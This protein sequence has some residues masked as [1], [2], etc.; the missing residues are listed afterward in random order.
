MKLLITG[1]LGHIGSRLIREVPRHFPLSELVMIDNLSTQRYTSLFN[2]PCDAIYRF[3]EDDV[4]EADL[5]SL[6]AGVD[7]VIHLAAI[8]DAAGSFQIR[9]KIELVNYNTTKKVADS[10]VS[11]GIPMIHLSSTSVYGTQKIT[12]DEDCSEE[13]LRP[14]SPYAETKLREERLLQEMAASKGL[15][16]VTCRF[17]TIVGISP[18]M[19]F[20]TAAN[21][22]CWQ[23]VLGHPL[24]VWRTALHQKRPYLAIN[25][26]MDALFFL[27]DK[28]CF[29]GRVYNV[30]TE[31]LTVNDVIS[32]IR[33]HVGE[34]M[35]DYVD[36]EIMNQLSY[37]VSSRR[38][39]D[40][41]FA[42]TGSIEKN[43]I[44][45][46]GILQGAG[47]YHD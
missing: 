23:A 2:L 18:G 27:L 24:T 6:M 36:A 14:Q 3:I 19:R 10:C 37:E 8:T 38:F 44:E 9:E 16:F 13:D 30:V 29:D 5:P 43:I 33:P 34:V 28:G 25:D 17:G 31:N 46:I 41:G 20:H 21:K 35:V 26:A 22:F 45:T 12:V 4:L 42:F 15:R 11:L 7:A 39:R 1:P 47:G 40:L 32:W